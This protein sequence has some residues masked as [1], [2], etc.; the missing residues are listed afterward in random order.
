MANGLTAIG[1]VPRQNGFHEIEIT[2]PPALPVRALFVEASLKTW[3][4]AFSKV[5]RAPSERNRFAPST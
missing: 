5:T 1:L 4:P 2:P 3:T